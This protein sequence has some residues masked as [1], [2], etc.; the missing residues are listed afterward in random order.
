MTPV[1]KGGQPVDTAIHPRP[2]PAAEV[3]DPT[4][5]SGDPS[6]FTPDEDVLESE[7]PIENALEKSFPAS[8]TRKKT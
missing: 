7:E 3:D 6:Q 8:P 2:D 5:E 1:K 4:R